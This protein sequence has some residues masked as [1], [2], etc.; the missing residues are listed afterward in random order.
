MRERIV[1]VNTSTGESVT[2]PEAQVLALA[3][4]VP[5]FTDPV[6][7]FNECGCCVSLHEREH[8]HAGYVIGS[9]GG[10]DWIEGD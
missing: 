1:V 7:H 4:H 5:E 3:A 6:W 2:M 10:C 8:P 9:D